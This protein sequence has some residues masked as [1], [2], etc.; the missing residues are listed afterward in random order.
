MVE[1]SFSVIIKLLTAYIRSERGSTMAL[2][3]G[4][5]RGDEEKGVMGLESVVAEA[6]TAFISGKTKSFDWRQSQ[7]RAL[8]RL[9]RERE[10]DMFKVLKED[11]GKHRVEAF[12]D[13][14]LFTCI[15]EIRPILRTKTRKITKWIFSL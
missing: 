11:L 10:D 9:L 8:L 15:N 5:E 14:V 7:L 13:E 2:S 6:R 4:E 1:I 3:T 12:R